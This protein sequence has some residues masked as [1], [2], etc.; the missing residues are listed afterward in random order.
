MYVNDRVCFPSPQISYSVVDVMA[1]RQNAAGAFS[2]PPF[3][4]PLGP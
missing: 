4:V 3:H 2:L 1:L